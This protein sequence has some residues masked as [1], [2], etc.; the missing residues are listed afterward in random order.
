MVFPNLL[1]ES[2]RKRKVA[3]RE[4][5]H[6]SGNQGITG[7]VQCTR[8]ACEFA[9]F[10][11]AAPVERRQR[12]P[13]MAGRRLLDGEHLAQIRPATPAAWT[14]DAGGPARR[15]TLYPAGHR[16][17]AGGGNRLSCSVAAIRIPVYQGNDGCSKRYSR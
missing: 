8:A 5:D 7:A 12:A 6:G 2:E 14:L 10:G 4:R 9:G 13:P 15:A 11:P 3:T 16:R 1:P 17:P